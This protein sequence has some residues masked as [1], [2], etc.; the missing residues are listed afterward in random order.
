MSLKF[1]RELWAGDI[2]VGGNS[3]RTAFRSKRLSGITNRVSVDG[4]EDQGLSPGT[5][6]F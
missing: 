1:K 4:V 2:N 3:I 5:L 6:Q